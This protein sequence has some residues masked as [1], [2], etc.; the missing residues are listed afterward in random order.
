MS[1]GEIRQEHV[2]GWRAAELK[3][4]RSSTRH[5]GR[6]LSPNLRWRGLAGL[7]RRYLDLDGRCVR[8]VEAVYEFGQLVKGSLA[9]SEASKP[10]MILPEL[11][12]PE[13]RRHLETVF[14]IR[15]L[16]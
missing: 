10:M 13:L 2:R 5:S 6:S 11:I 16:L 4:T 1:I 8:V 3:P 12:M 9:K 15:R 7:R 14:C